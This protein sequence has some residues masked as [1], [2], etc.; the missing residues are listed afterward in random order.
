MVE[1]SIVCY[2]DVND[3]HDVHDDDCDVH[4]SFFIVR[5]IPL[6]AVCLRSTLNV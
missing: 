3:V 5:E 2:D 1:I 4:S 6:P